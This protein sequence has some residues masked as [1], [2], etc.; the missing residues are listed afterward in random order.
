MSWVTTGAD[1]GTMLT[2]IS[3]TT[4]TFLWGRT[5]IRE[6]RADRDN[7]RERN[8]SGYIIRENVP[9]WFV[10]LV[11]DEHARWS[12]KVVLDVVN[13]DGTPNTDMAR[14]LRLY[15]QDGGTLTRPPSAAQWDFL[16]DLRQARFGAPKGYPIL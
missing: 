13:R 8:W 14:L 10:R 9:T 16:Q 15:V 1:F 2:G 6:W 7:R 11:V 4:A 12:E 5:R 3:A